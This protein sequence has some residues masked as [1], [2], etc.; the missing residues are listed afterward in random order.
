MGMSSEMWLAGWSEGRDRC[1]LVLT[2]R[3]ILAELLVG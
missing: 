3:Q 1:L 2:G